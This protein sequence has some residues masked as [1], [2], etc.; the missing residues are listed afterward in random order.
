MSQVSSLIIER[1]KRLP[2]RS[3]ERWQGGLVRLPT[4]V[5]RGPESKPYRPWAAIWVSHSTG[6][7]HLKVEPEPGAHDW[8]LALEVL[9]EFGLKAKLA[10]G[11]PESLEVA[12]EGLGARLLGALG[13]RDLGLTV[14]SDLPAVRQALAAMHEYAERAPLPPDALDAPGVTVD[15]MRAFAGAAKRFYEAAPWRHLTDEDL[16][17]V[18][19][20]KK[21]PGLRHVVVLIFAL[22]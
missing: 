14:S 19:A 11:R 8:T 7:V 20:P 18:E 21:E 15:R 4:W 6:L 22:V 10:G 3:G 2:R 9:L 5:D 17:H 1:F 13:D 12:D 16:I